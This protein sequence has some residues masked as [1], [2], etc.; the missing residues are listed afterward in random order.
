V[1]ARLLPIGLVTLAVLAFG[2]LAG[3]AGPDPDGT[4]QPI[5]TF[6]SEQASGIAGPVDR[7]ATLLPTDC[8]DVIS[9]DAMSAL[10]GKPMDSVR[11]HTVVGVA[12]AAVGRLERVSCQYQLAG[13]KAAPPALELNLAAYAT[14]SAADRQLSTNAVAERSSA[15]RSEDLTIG[16]A[17]A[18]LFG[19]R[20]Q[21]V[22]LVT[23]GCSSVTVTLRD[24]VVVGAQARAIM[25]D[26]AQRVLPHLAPVLASSS[27]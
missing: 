8:Q 21:S 4:R 26:L 22:L 9:G 12:A 1:R 17:R 10:L 2:A 5:P 13:A 19:E 6:A 16:T 23:S 7:R 11:P 18:V 27:R 24:G 3:C 25:I 14:P 15:E 20:G